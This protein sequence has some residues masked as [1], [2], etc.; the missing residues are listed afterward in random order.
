[1][2]K[3]SILDDPRLDWSLLE[4]Y[5]FDREAFQSL[6]QEIREKKLSSKSAFFTGRI[7]PVDQVTE[8]D[9]SNE[10]HHELGVQALR[11]SQ[12]AIVVLNGGMATRFGNVVKGTVEVFDGKSFLELKAEDARHASEHFGA[13][14]PLVLMNSFATKSATQV[15]F[16]DNNSFALRPED[17]LSFEQ[18]IS[19]RM[20]PDGSLFIGSDKK[21]S[22]HAPGHGDF[23]E[24]IRSSGVL[25]AL[26]ERSCKYILFSNVDNLGATIEA[27]IIGQHIHSKA[28]MT[29]ELTQRRQN[30]KGVWD[31][32]G[33]PAIIDGKPQLLEGFRFPKE[34]DQ[35]L[36]PDFSTNNFIFS[37]ED[38][39]REL[40]LPRHVVEKKVEDKTVLQLESITCE[41]SGLYDASGD[42]LLKVNYLRVPRDGLRGR[43]F[44]VK[45]RSD[46]EE[47]RPV[48]K[49]RL[50][51]GRRSRA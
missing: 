42:P 30:A 10:E 12:V 13:H 51:A 20:N 24:G 14:I 18:S 45:S 6:A 37:L 15:H 3:H 28:S 17:V 21:P 29:A 26:R 44:P 41:A 5:R 33:A 50:D 19:L 39:D 11:N 48:L 22:Y 36:L 32:G 47:L 23:F 9:W 1:M 7:E 46:L 35:S 31:K 38:I 4:A 2:K 49:Q 27:N 16:A 25:R 8:L 40:V 34:F 43:F